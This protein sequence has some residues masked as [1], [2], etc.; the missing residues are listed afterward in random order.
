MHIAEASRHVAQMVGWLMVSDPRNVSDTVE[1][2][3]NI[4]AI[5][6]LI[7]RRHFF[8]FLFCLQV[9]FELV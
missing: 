6:T 2:L 4:I 9:L 3:A 8:A 1:H 7:A 5:V